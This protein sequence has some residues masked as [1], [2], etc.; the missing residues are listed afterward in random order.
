MS[1]T[2]PGAQIHSMERVERII[3]I[4]R[5]LRVVYDQWTQ[6]QDFPGFVPALGEVRQLDATRLRCRGELSGRWSEWDVQI[7]D[8]VPDTLISWKHITGSPAAGTVRFESLNGERTQV[9]LIIAWDN[10]RIGLDAVASHVIEALESFRQFI[11][12]RDAPTGGW[13]G[14]V[15]RGIT[16]GDIL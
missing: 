15:D 9:R 1:T 7:T 10:A 8:Q 6:F 2:A 14:E 5:P 3:D 4:D 13:H 16:Q 12:T 11:E